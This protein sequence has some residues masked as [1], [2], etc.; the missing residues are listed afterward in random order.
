ME[1]L[2]AIILKEIWAL[3]RDPKGRIILFAPPLLQLL[4]FTFATT[5][6]VNDARIGVLDRSGGV[7]SSELVQQI[8]ASDN[9]AEIRRL[10]SHDDLARAIDDQ[11]IIAAIIF[12]PTFDRNLTKGKTATVGIVLDGRRSNASQIVA[13]Y[14][15]SI[16]ASA[17]VSADKQTATMTSGARSIAT[18]WYNPSLDYI[19][20][21]LPSLIAI[22]SAVAGLSVT[23]QSVAR[24][25]ELGTFDQLM[26]SPLR[27][28]EILIGK[29]IPPWLL[30]MLNGTIFLAVATLFFQVPFTGSLILFYLSLAVY[31]LA[32]IGVG[33]FVS[34]ASTTQ[35]QAFLGSFLAMVPIILLSGYASP[36]E[37]MPEWLQMT[38]LINPARYFVVLVQGLFL[39]AMPFDMVVQQLWPL[40]L[41]ALA[42]LSA[43]A[44]LFR[45]RME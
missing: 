44:W 26:V 17:N 24:E 13:G 40:G 33:M 25:R 1:R 28:H 7:Q 2:R 37:N 5:L 8:S 12:E 16:I 14:I 10:S 27:V 43:S 4:V 29:M 38:T 35:Q 42:T 41:I 32:L 9:F 18:N 3:L 34:A 39:K 15:S 19:W 31:M 36:I 23:A 11:E 45:A 30:G 20:F 6:D 22:V 21:T